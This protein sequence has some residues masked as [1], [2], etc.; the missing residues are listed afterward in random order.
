M[1]VALMASA[2]SLQA[3]LQ[4]LECHVQQGSSTIGCFDPNSQNEPLGS[5][6]HAWDAYWAVGSG[7][8]LIS[9]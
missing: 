9:A 4:A 8:V 7:L 5:L 3:T 1:A 2:S 6:Q